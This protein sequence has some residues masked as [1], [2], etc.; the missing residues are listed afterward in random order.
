MSLQLSTKDLAALSRAST[1][2][3]SPFSDEDG[4]SWQ[5]AACSAVQ[6]VVGADASSSAV[7]AAGTTLLGGEPD[8][9]SVLQVIFPPPEWVSDA[10]IVQRNRRMSVADWSDVFDVD[11][12]RRSAF[13]NDV[14]RPHRLLAPIHMMEDVAAGQLPASLTVYYADEQAAAAQVAERKQKLQLL[15][16][17]FRAG[18]K[19]Y[20]CLAQHRAASVAL[21]EATSSGVLLFDTKGHV[22][23]E[24]SAFARM[25]AADFER[26]RVRREIA[27]IAAS[28]AAL[29]IRR[30]AMTVTARPASSELRTACARYRV[31]AVFMDGGWA[32]SGTTIVVLVDPITTTGLGAN[33]LTARFHLTPREIEIA[34]L[35]RRGLSSSQIGEA[36]GIS[37]NTV[38]RHVEHLLVKLDIHSRSAIASRLAGN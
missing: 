34:Q 17:A 26:Q 1:I 2:L 19:A 24:N 20:I 14:V 38:R 4:E 18:M 29:M 31:S 8:I 6:A 25:L 5:R 32:G 21:A 3:L 35:V 7:P 30:N 15:L 9:V 12:V 36:L 13:Y 22:L 16:P 27:R 28:L 23:F 37:V 11:R 10:L 33:E